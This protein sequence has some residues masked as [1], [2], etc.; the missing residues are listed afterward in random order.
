ML[1]QFKIIT[2]LPPRSVAMQ[3]VS[4]TADPQPCVVSESCSSKGLGIVA[5]PARETAWIYTQ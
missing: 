2:D 3:I 5:D 4:K 1:L